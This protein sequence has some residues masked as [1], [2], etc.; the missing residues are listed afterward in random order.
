M[1]KVVCFTLNSSRVPNLK[2]I[3]RVI[4]NCKDIQSKFVQELVPSIHKNL[5]FTTVHEIEVVDRY[6]IIPVVLDLL[7][8]IFNI[9][10]KS[11]PINLEYIKTL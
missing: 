1:L 3:I 2:K 11:N 6:D 4:E 10:I 5:I 8:N 9:M 7:A